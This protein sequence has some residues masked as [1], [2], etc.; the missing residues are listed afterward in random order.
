MPFE[1]RISEPAL[2]EELITTLSRHGCIAYRQS[3]ESCRVVHVHAAHSDEAERELAFF[4]RAWGL[5]H[6]GV[7]AAI[8]A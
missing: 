2:L 6:P 7:A 5:A 8:S 3:Q 4:V 1:V